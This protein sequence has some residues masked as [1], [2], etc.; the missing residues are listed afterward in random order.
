MRRRP[1]IKNLRNYYNEIDGK[2][3]FKKKVLALTQGPNVPSTRFRWAQYM[4][5]LRASGLSVCESAS[6]N[7]AYAPP[8]KG[9]RPVWFV[10]SVT[11]SLFR[12]ID[13]NTTDV[14]FLQRNLIATLY[15]WEWV[16]KRPLV[17]DV[18][19]AIFIGPR[20]G[21]ANKIAKLA[22]VIIC[23][24]NYIAEHFSRYG[25]IEVLPTAI[26]ADRFT[27]AGTTDGGEVIIGWSGTSGGFDYLYSVEDALADV[28]NARPNVF[29]KVVSDR[30]PKFRLL[31]AN[32]IRFVKWSPENEVLEVQS[33]TV[34]IMPLFDNPW[35]RGKCSFKMLTY[36]AVGIP[37]LVSPVGMNNEVLSLGECGIPARSK[38][39]W[40]EALIHLVD[41]QLRRRKMGE[42]GRSIVETHYSKKV[43]GPKLAAIL[44]STV[45]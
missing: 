4:P 44:A 27:P 42:I 32:R 16:I 2:M 17:F 20:G 18:D 14:C 5:D 15:T 25:K 12:A 37:V 21:A 10:K 36:M 33:F 41:D 43:I 19:D 34:G 45:S 35:A 22:D 40:V 26:D 31:S 39:Q 29:L 9:R 28:I 7:G 23:G 38:D 8:S 11:E 1:V 6:L 24:N 30:A 3:I 13:A